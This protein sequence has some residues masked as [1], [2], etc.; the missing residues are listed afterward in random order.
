[1][2]RV[3]GGDRPRG[4]TRGGWRSGMLLTVDV[5]N[6]EITVGLFAGERLAAHWR[7]TTVANRTPDEWA[8]TLTGHLTLAGH[9]ANEVRAAVLA[10]V[11]P[12]V[13]EDLVAGIRQATGQRP[14]TVGPS[15]KLPL[16]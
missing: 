11:A 9:S 7:L 10:S 8:V 16:K 12:A 14:V 3:A 15:S 4:A 6:T 13:T 1:A 2:G 5:G